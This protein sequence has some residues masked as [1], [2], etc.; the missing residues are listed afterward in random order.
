[1]YCKNI[2]L[3]ICHIQ[4]ISNLQCLRSHKAVR[5]I[6][7]QIYGNNIKHIIINKDACK[8]TE[9]V[10]SIA[11]QL[12]NN[13]CKLQDNR[14]RCWDGNTMKMEYVYANTTTRATYEIN[15][16][17][18]AKESQMTLKKSMLQ[19]DRSHGDL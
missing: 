15:F 7:R 12:I 10:R 2:P 14:G 6:A 13:V 8:A 16:R 1:M 9:A 3:I 11:R 4:S 17:L 19:N 18:E 5:S